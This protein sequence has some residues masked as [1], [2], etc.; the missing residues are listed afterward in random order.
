MRS[1]GPVLAILTLASAVAVLSGAT[2]TA[3][4]RS[5]TTP[6]EP[7]SATI[8]TPVQPIGHA[9][10]WLVD[11][12]GRVLLIHGVNVSMKGSLAQSRAYDF[13]ANDAAYLA[14]NGFNAVRLTVERY[15]VEPS[16]GHFDTTYLRFIRHIVTTLNRHH[17]L[18]LID[19]HQDEF[20]PVFR[21]NGYPA[22]MT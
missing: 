8:A 15:D 4:A 10:R 6:P 21:D 11:A 19:F 17:I 2:L 20:G 14:A 16:P 13:G 12:H 18:T 22:W 9:G 3:A 1:R 7:A 5:I